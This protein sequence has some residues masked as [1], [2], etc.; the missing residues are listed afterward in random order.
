VRRAASAVRPG[1]VVVFHDVAGYAPTPTLPPIDLLK[2]TTE[3]LAAPV[4]AGL[5]SPDIAG[6]LIPCFEDAGLPEPQM[7][8][9][10]IVGGSGSPI[11]RWI[12]ATYRALSPGLIIT[13]RLH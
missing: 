2:V 13:L 12:A 7:I 6:R 10:A 9:E 11:I 3:G 1:G 5:P 8:R 4:R